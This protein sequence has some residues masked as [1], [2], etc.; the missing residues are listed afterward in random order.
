M[1]PKITARPT[2][3]ITLVVTNAV[4]FLETAPFTPSQLSATPE[5]TMPRPTH[6][7]PQSNRLS[8]GKKNTVSNH[9]T[10]T[11]LPLDV[12]ENADVR[13]NLAEH[14][15]DGSSHPAQHPEEQQRHHADHRG[16]DLIV[17]DRRREQS[18][19]ATGGAHEREPQEPKPHRAPIQGTTL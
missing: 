8:S 17:R 5:S 9:V 18:H 3:I 11:R 19:R 4:L 7:L 10:N 13:E 16:N 1:A 6:T 2:V 14:S 12:A 15:L